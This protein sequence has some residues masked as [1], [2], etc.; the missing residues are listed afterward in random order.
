MLDLKVI[1]E[2]PDLLRTALSNRQT[3]LDLDHLLRLDQERR[4]HLSRVEALKHEKNV[5]SEEI[6]QAKRKGEE[7]NE[8]VQKSKTL[9]QDIGV[10]EHQVGDIDTKL[11]SFMIGIPNIPHKSVPI[12]PDDASNEVIRSWGEPPTFSF[13]PKEHM[14]LAEPLGLVDLER[15]AKVAG[16]NFVVFRGMGARL[17]RG[18]INFMLDLHTR[19]HGYVEIAPP[20]LANRAAMTGT[21]QLPKL[22]EDMYQLKDDELFLIPTAEVPLTNLHM[23]E[24]LAEADLPIRYVAYTCCFR[25]E[26]G[27]YGRDTRGLMRVHQFDKV[28]LVKF[29]KPESSYDELETLVTHAEH[30]LQALEL[31]YRVV[32]LSTG[33]LSFASAKCYDLEVWAPGANRW[34]EVSSCS[35]FESFQARR[36]GIRYRPS[37]G[38]G[39]SYVHTL[40]GSGV[41]LPRTVIGILENHQQEDGSVLIPKALRPYVN[42]QEI[43]EPTA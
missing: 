10:I 32:A 6:G 4:S 18:L 30:V 38:G 13:K 17:E 16:S 22:E 27:S 14:S 1:R 11:S 21:G 43:L 41:A 19:Q 34:L 20:Y 9:S 8:N 40:N 3:Q 37:E 7:A 2:D 29:V 31:P 39:S 25:R 36:A 5:L 15:A 35:N 24:V 33:E 26:A 42:G 23:D 12:G 28:E